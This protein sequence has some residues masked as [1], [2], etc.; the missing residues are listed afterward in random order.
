VEN[1]KGMALVWIAPWPMILPSSHWIPYVEVDAPFKAVSPDCFVVPLDV[2][3]ICGVPFGLVVNG[4]KKAQSCP[5]FYCAL[6]QADP[7]LFPVPHHLLILSNFESGLAAFVITRSKPP[8][9]DYR[10]VMEKVNL[11][12]LVSIFARLLL[13]TG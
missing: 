6:I 1:N 9:L 12:I 10:H 2:I 5:M 4:T 13:F 11:N 3:G 8:F 7:S